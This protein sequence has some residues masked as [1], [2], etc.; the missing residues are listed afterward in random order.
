[1]AFSMGKLNLWPASAYSKQKVDSAANR[2]IIMINTTPFERL[3]WGFY[4]SIVLPPINN[5]EEIGNQFADK[6]YL[7]L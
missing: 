3:G 6:T 7:N 4:Y 5:S 1:M 2:T